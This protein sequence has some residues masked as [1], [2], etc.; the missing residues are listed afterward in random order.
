MS[1]ARQSQFIPASPDGVFTSEFPAR[2]R[3]VRI[4]AICA[5]I[6]TDALSNGLIPALKVTDGGGN[7]I[8]WLVGSPLIPASDNFVTFSTVPTNYTVL[9]GAVP[10]LVDS[11]VQ[12][13]PLPP[14]LWIDPQSRIV[15]EA[16]KAIA[17]DEISSVNWTF[18]AAAED[19]RL[20]IPG[21]Q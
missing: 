15:I 21:A 2:D 5:V 14:D 7:I 20:N 11:A 4:V 3:A 1:R 17:A 12:V 19:L 16:L 13:I 8:L 6:T 18:E 9:A 10:I